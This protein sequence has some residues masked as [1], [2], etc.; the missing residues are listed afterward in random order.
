MTKCTRY[1]YWNFESPSLSL[2]FWQINRQ[3]HKQTQV[4]CPP[5]FEFVIPIFDICSY[6]YRISPLCY[7]SIV[8]NSLFVV[9]TENKRG[10]IKY[11]HHYK[12]N[13]TTLSVASP[14][15]HT[16]QVSRLRWETPAF[17]PLSA[18]VHLPRV[19]PQIPWLSSNLPLFSRFR[20]VQQER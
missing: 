17:W 8:C 7:S 2:C 18:S 6:M 11:C 15:M 5:N 9:N 14:C 1:E 16:C 19:S 13:K 12:F 10:H 20:N 3:T 4:I